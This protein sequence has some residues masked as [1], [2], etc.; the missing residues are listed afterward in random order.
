[1]LLKR[2]KFFV[3]GDAQLDG[4]RFISNLVD[5]NKAW[6]PVG[7]IFVDLYVDK[8]GILGDRFVTVAV[9]TEHFL[10]VVDLPVKGT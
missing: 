6:D 7:R 3:F 9:R 4:L 5:L 10:S 1:M 8:I 2:M